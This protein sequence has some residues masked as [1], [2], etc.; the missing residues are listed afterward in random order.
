M[1]DHPVLLLTKKLEQH[2]P[3][4]IKTFWKLSTRKK[5]AK[6]YKLI[7]TAKN[8]A[9]LEKAL[10]FK[11]LTGKTYSPKA[12]DLWRN[13]VRVLKA[14]LERFVAENEHRLRYEEDENYQGWLVMQGFDRIKFK[15]GIIEKGQRLQAK[16]SFAGDYQFLLDIE[17]IQ[18]L[19]YL[20][21]EAD[22]KKL[23]EGFGDVVKSWETTL[24]EYIGQQ[25][26]KVNV[27]IAQYNSV[28][29]QHQ[30]PL[31]TIPL[32]ADY[33]SRHLPESNI[34]NYYKYYSQ[35]FEGDFETKI[36]NFN[37]ALRFIEPIAARN[38]LF[39]TRRIV[40]QISLAR[41]LSGHGHFE[42]AHEL[43]ASVKNDID[44]RYIDYKSVFYVNYVTNLVKFKRYTE[45]LQILD[46]EL[47][48][49]NELYKNMLL[50]S[51]LLCYLNLRD[52]QSIS[53][54]I[55]FDLDEAPFPQN[56][57]LK[58]IKS[59][60]FYLMKEPELAAQMMTNL[61][62]TKDA[63]SRMHAYL[64]IGTLYKKLYTVA[65]KNKGLKRW[66]QA[67]INLLV[68]EIEKIENNEPEWL[69]LVSVYV[70]LKGE[71]ESIKAKSLT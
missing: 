15:E 71:V 55:S 68:K 54:Y 42:K 19:N 63:N 13:E 62:N 36:Q 45:A 2:Y 40:L 50:Q 21:A 16:K 67:D 59:A 60:Y 12:D 66:K 32:F 18:L 27:L 41:E 9:Q 24:A 64:P 53:G 35:S 22:I 14:E 46:N 31:V 1:V 23:L 47:M 65:V 48:N 34:S 7:V 17:F 70:W 38:P 58:L 52:T 6:L 56:Y 10:L 4:Q 39:A 30:N 44:T 26:G 49:P 69:K 20:T 43:L 5:A 61:L 3:A 8:D 57:M 28:S 25:L 37:K 33:Y 51:R 29:L 11:K